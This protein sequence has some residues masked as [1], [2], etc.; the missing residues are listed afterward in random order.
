MNAPIE[1]TI[2]SVD[3]SSKKVQVEPGTTA[4]MIL[5]QETIECPA[6]Y[7][8]RLVTESAQA[9]AGL[10]LGARKEQ[11]ALFLFTILSR[12]MGVSQSILYR[13]PKKD[14]PDPLII[15]RCFVLTTV[16]PL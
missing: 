10:R 8:A 1:V 14:H 5:H 11:E 12:V 16:P 4:A 7:Q 6:G 9:V 13:I 3:G 2:Q 15:H